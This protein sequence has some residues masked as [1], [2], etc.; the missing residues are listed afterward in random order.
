MIRK[1][2][3]SNAAGRDATINFQGLR[4]D[5]QAK[6]GLP[7]R[8]VEFFRYL[9][10]TETGL[11][12]A[13]QERFGEDYGQALVDGDPETDIER[14][15]QR[16]G[17]TDRVYLSST[18]DV[19]YAPPSVVEL[20]IGADGEEKERRTPV[21]TEANVADE[22]TALRW[23]GRTLKLDAAARRFVFSRTVQVRHVD[24]LSY[25]YLF[26]MAKELADEKSVVMIGGGGKG[27][28]PLIFQTNG[29]PYRGFLEGR[30]EGEKYMLLLH[31]SN[32]EL[33]RPE[34]GDA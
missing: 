34:T 11:H 2:H 10:C 32:M 23:T 25:D 12:D 8:D 20:I 21:E 22:M 14:V 4:P 17:R 9:A 15:G 19:L 28:E 5:A 26:A 6:P 18:G 27:R 30:V 24:G 29:T 31:L 1:I 13:L 3:L 33:K 7:G 16:I